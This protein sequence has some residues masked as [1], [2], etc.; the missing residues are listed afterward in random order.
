[1]QARHKTSN[2]TFLKV[3][4]ALDLVSFFPALSVSSALLVEAS[5]V[6]AVFGVYY[7]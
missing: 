2:T 5:E 1:M 6:R 3:I 7:T 4:V